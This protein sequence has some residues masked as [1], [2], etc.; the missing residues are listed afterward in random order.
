[1]TTTNVPEDGENEHLKNKTRTNIQH[2]GVPTRHI[3]YIPVL[4]Q[5]FE[6]NTNSS[7]F[8][9]LSKKVSSSK[10]LSQYKVFLSS[11]AVFLQK[12]RGRHAFLWKVTCFVSLVASLTSSFLTRHKFAM[13]VLVTFACVANLQVGLSLWRDKV[14]LS[15]NSQ[16]TW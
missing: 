15:A 2:A 6:Q 11:F 7:I 3:S 14:R 9:P 1:M 12:T 8:K 16:R 5:S 4:S 13:S 10:F